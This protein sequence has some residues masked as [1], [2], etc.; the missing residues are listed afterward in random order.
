MK[1]MTIRNIP[2]EVADFISKMAANEGRSVNSMTVALLAKAAGIDT[3]RPK[4]RD[5]SWL[6]GTWPERE[7][8]RFDAAVAACRR[9]NPEDWK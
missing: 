5:L 3:P 6:A 4:R 2:G 1:T 8:R 7:A 9:I